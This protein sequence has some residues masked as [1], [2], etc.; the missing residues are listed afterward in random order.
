LP[1]DI[2]KNGSIIKLI[3]FKRGK[4]EKSDMIAELDIMKVKA[5]AQAAKMR[6]Q[7]NARY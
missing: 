2:F 5:I 1:L 6:R 4:H 3:K 7:L